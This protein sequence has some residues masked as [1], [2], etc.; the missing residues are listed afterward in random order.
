MISVCIATYNGEKYIKE[1]INSI[2]YQLEENDEIIVSDDGSTDKTLEI[3]KELNDKRIKIFYNNGLKGHTYNFESALTHS[4]GDYIFFS[5]QD[6]VWLPNKVR[7][8]SEYLKKYSAV[9]SDA[10]VVDE[11]LNTIKPSFFQLRN[12]GK[13]VFKNFYKNS[14]F[15]FG[16]AFNK[17]LL[18]FALPFPVQKEMGHDMIL[19]FIAN[20][21][22][23]IIFIDDK[24]TLYRRHDMSVT[25]L[26]TKQ[27]RRHLIEIAIGRISK[28]FYVS[29][30]YLRIILR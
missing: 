3:I 22:N 14:Y 6:D 19:G 15:G 2:L 29:K 11:Y 8:M 13:G 16:M 4:S 27:K 30:L 25:R 10:V 12:S 28:L 21:K 24:L 9:F 7:I 20:M 5:D 23:S 26:G 1:Q 18:H 17:D